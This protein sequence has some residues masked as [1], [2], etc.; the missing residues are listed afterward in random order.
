[1]NVTTDAWYVRWFRYNCVVLD[2]FTS[3]HVE[4][5]HNGEI[6]SP[7]WNRYSR[8]TNLCQFMRTLVL[9][10][11]VLGVT[12][13]FYAFVISMLFMPIYFLGATTVGTAVGIVVAGV[14]AV[15]GLVYFMLE[16][17]PKAVRN[18]GNKLSDMVTPS[19]EGNPGILSVIWLWAKGVA[20]KFC[21]TITFKR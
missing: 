10:T 8:G 13:A 6:D 17:F 15:L 7:R 12:L 5:D 19:P 1:M 16:L 3:N 18:V 20:K 9:G 11:L 4:F 14:I 21:P 2:Q